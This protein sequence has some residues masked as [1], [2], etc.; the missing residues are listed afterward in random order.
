MQL[1][2]DELQSLM[3]KINSS[4]EETRK[5]FF[6]LL[7]EGSLLSVTNLYK[8]ATNSN[9]RK[10][11]FDFLSKGCNKKVASVIANIDYVYKYDF[12]L[13]NKFLLAL[14]LDKPYE[15]LSKELSGLL[16][17]YSQ[18]KK[19][20]DFVEYVVNINF[21]EIAKVAP[22]VAEYSAGMQLI[23]VS[24]HYKRGT[25]KF[26][27]ESLTFEF[28][29]T[30]YLKENYLTVFEINDLYITHPLTSRKVGLIP[31]EWLSEVKEENLTEIRDAVYNAIV[32]FDLE[33]DEERFVQD[34]SNIIKKKAQVEHLGSGDVGEVYKV[35]IGEEKAF[36]IKLFKKSYIEESDYD[37]VH[38]FKINLIH[39]EYQEPLIALFVNEHSN[40]FVK[41]YFGQISVIVFRQN[42]GFMV[43]EYLGEDIVPTDTCN[44]DGIYKI[45]G[46]DRKPAHFINGKIIDFGDVFISKIS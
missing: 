33:R 14:N 17:E 6:E 26:D 34:L 38:Y 7:E 37:E 12:K 10:L 36:C 27:E 32:K 46:R 8:I 24:N 45:R 22:I 23:F 42:D 31:P 15:K 43:T 2:Q 4:S 3:S 5:L 30:N 19:L 44:K 25:K 39:G 1:P 20:S 9:I 29:I 11:Y 21:G 41:M 35:T 28:D 18:T 16:K 13:I 40:E